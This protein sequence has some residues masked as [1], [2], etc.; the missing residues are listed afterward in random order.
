VQRL[1]NE[2]SVFPTPFLVG[3]YVRNHRG[4]SCMEAPYTAALLHRKPTSLGTSPDSFGVPDGD[5]R[6]AL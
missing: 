4:L 1:K 6:N 3:L 5:E 2:E